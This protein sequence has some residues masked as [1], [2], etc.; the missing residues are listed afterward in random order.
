MR[1][2]QPPTLEAE[3]RGNISC[4]S[5]LSW[6]LSAAA[7]GFLRG[8]APHVHVSTLQSGLFQEEGGR[9]CGFQPWLCPGVLCVLR[10]VAFPL[11]ASVSSSR[12]SDFAFSPGRHDGLC[13]CSGPLFLQLSKSGL[14]LLLLYPRLLRVAS[15]QVLPGCEE[16]LALAP[17][18]R[19]CRFVPCWQA[20]SR[21]PPWSCR[22]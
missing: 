22:F 13:K 11:W 12:K 3:G 17:L 10:Q 9:K 16:E 20:G 5:S 7:A 19:S 6:L 2:S 8:G 1:W 4:I 18:P 21:G 15:T 14:H